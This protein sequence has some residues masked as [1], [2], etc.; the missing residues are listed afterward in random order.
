MFSLRLFVLGDSS[1]LPTGDKYIIS[2][3]Q[4]SIMIGSDPPTQE[5][6]AGVTR[7]AALPQKRIGNV[8]AMRAYRINIRGINVVFFVG[9]CVSVYLCNL[10]L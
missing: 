3:V 1:L 6:A 7:V 5:W 9:S 8:N 10:L 2:W 4:T